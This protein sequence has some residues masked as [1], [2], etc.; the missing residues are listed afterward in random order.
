MLEK[1]NQIRIDRSDLILK[2]PE[3]IISRLIQMKNS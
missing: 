1:I 3:I 2:I